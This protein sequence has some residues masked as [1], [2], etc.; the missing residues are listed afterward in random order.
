MRF[1]AACSGSVDVMRCIIHFYPGNVE[2]P[3]VFLLTLLPSPPLP[4]VPPPSLPHRRNT[5]DAFYVLSTTWPT[6]TE[7]FEYSNVT[8]T[9]KST[10][11]KL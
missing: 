6:L 3:T 2:P 8:N 10:V 4:P 11:S 1:A 9:A 5:L 7:A